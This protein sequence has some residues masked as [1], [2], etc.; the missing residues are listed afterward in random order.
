MLAASAVPPG[1]LP[2]PADDL[3]PS[4][5][6]NGGATLTAASTIHHVV[7]AYRYRKRHE[8]MSGIVPGV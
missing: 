8:Y 3:V 7:G 6:S 5:S 1:T 2:E 4:L